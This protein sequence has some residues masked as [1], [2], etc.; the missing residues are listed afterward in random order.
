MIKYPLLICLLLTVK[1]NGQD[2]PVGYEER[3]V[4]CNGQFVKKCVP[5]NYT[6]KQCW[7]VSHPPC[8]G[9][10][11]GGLSFY[12]SYEKAY[13]MANKDK[14][15]ALSMGSKYSC[16]GP[17]ARTY[18]IYLDDSKYCNINSNE[19]ST[20]LNDLKNKITLFLKRYKAEISNYKRYFSGQ[21][22]KPGA[23]YN[24]YESL[25]KQA[26]KN[27]DDLSF[28]INGLIDDNLSE[29]ESAFEDVK[30]DEKK[31]I[32]V[33][34]TYRTSLNLGANANTQKLQFQNRD[35]EYL[36]K[37]QDNSQISNTQQSSK[38]QSQLKYEQNSSLL[39]TLGSIGSMFLESRHQQTMNRLQNFSEAN[40]QN[41]D[42][43]YNLNER[44]TDAFFQKNY[45]ELLRISLLKAN[46]E[47]DEIYNNGI[48]MWRGIQ[49]FQIYFFKGTIKTNTRDYY[50]NNL[51]E[52]IP[53][54]FKISYLKSFKNE[55]IRNNFYDS[56][57]GLIRN[58]ADENINYGGNTIKIK[59]AKNISLRYN[60]DLA[61]D[62]LS[63]SS[64]IAITSPYDLYD[65]ISANVWNIYL[66][67]KKEKTISDLI[68]NIN[69]I[70][71]YFRNIHKTVDESVFNMYSQ[72]PELG[73][74]IM[75]FYLF[76]GY[77]R[78]YE[79]TKDENLKHL[80]LNQTK[81]IH[82]ADG[83]T[84]L[85]YSSNYSAEYIKKVEDIFQKV[86]DF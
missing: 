44:G 49:P 43:I 12:S 72:F 25:L 27:A 80:I 52:Q 4:K 57:F 26:E 19:K 47:C 32:Q 8:A 69:Y 51:P 83:I 6:C 20:A 15:A 18:T 65:Y 59:C 63:K 29:L 14:N 73:Y 67:S 78:L 33:D 38:T 56:A 42:L 40:K 21:P 13:E 58:C 71:N 62:Y 24:E 46:K 10:K 55:Y 7:A 3:T 36:N 60:E 35:N 54:I 31:L 68:T 11:T 85:L 86:I 2:C 82:G 41:S 16:I 66:R 77:A 76:R 79:N 39:N 17:D 84:N 37:T 74:Q 34:A 81:E 28:R 1:A 23:I 9:F 22:Y 70:Q 53:D 64:A 50:H 45:E 48:D 61:I 75:L 30:N 5:L